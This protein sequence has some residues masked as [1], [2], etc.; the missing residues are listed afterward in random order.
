MKNSLTDAYS[1]AMI[2]EYMYKP[3]NGLN[4][5]ILLDQAKYMEKSINKDN[6]N[7]FSRVLLNSSTNSYFV[8]Q[9]EYQ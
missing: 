6:Y 4:W 3:T 7:D 1:S 2:K 5:Q 9:Y 8:R